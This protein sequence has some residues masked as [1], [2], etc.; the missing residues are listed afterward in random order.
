MIEIIGL[1]VADKLLCLAEKNDL[2]KIIGFASEYDLKQNSKSHLIQ[3]GRKVDLSEAWEYMRTI[4]E[5]KPAIAKEREIL[6]A[7]AEKLVE[8]KFILKGGGNG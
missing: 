8:P 7:I 1:G 6:I 4:R 5:L 3:V 2:A